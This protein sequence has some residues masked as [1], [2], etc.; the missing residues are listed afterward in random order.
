MPSYAVG[1]DAGDLRRRQFAGG[2]QQP[3]TVGQRPFALFVELA[4][5][6]WPDVFAP[7]VEFFLQLVFDQLALLLDH[8]DFFEAFGEAAH[9]VGLQRPDHADLVEADADLRSERIV[10]AEVIEGL[11]HIEVGLAG[12]DDSQ[13]GVGGVDHDLVQPVGAAVGQRR[14]ELVVEQARFLQQAVVRPAD[15]EA[16]RRQ[17]VVVGQDDPHAV[18]RDIHRGRGFDRIGD[19]LEADPAARIAAHGPAV[20]AEVEVVLHAG[21]YQH[22]H[23]CR[24]EGVL[25]LVRDGGRARG[26]VVAGHRQYAAMLPGAGRVGMLEDIAAAVDARPLAV[27]HAEYA[28]MFRA[29]R[30]VDLL[31]APQRRGG[32][33]LIDAGLEHHVV[34]RQM[35]LGFPQRLVEPAQRRTAVAADI[36]GGVE[37]GQRVALVLQQKKAHQR[38]GAGEEHP[39]CAERVLVF[40]RD[41]AQGCVHAGGRI[42]PGFRMLSGSMARLMARIRSMATSPCSSAM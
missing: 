28:V 18:G 32:E 22:R 34:L 7:V 38:L 10:D 9:A 16:L 19:R 30:Q 4:D 27:P 33:V 21:R 36:A 1:D 37:A 41:V 40:Q 11:A 2:G 14:V 17:G 6:A 23:H 5:H 8:Q 15:V 24:L 39:A 31:R 29:G 12:G 13:A 25:R 26:M 20:Q 35:R 3:A 42:L